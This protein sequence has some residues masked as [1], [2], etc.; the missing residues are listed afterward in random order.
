M[1]TAVQYGRRYKQRQIKMFFNSYVVVKKIELI[2]S[3]L[4]KRIFIRTN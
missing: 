4:Q 3:Q 1:V 2:L